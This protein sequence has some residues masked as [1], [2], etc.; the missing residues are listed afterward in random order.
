MNIL[1]DF[2]SNGVFDKKNVLYIVLETLGIMFT[3]LDDP[4]HIQD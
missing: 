3:L 4:L 1:E 2:S